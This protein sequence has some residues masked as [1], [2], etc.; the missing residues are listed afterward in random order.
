VA[1]VAPSGELD[2]ASSTGLRRALREAGQ[3]ARLVLLDLH[4]VTF[5]D[6]TILGLCVNFVKRCSRA[7]GPATTFMITHA[8]GVPL[9]AITLTGLSY[10]L[11]GDERQRADGSLSLSS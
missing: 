4:D 8:T 2:I 3:G 6:S 10:L 11:P 1:V 5:L 9:R 7:E